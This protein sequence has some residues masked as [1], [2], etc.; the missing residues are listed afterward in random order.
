MRDN[1][2]FASDG[3]KTASNLTSLPKQKL[4]MAKKGKAWRESCVDAIVNHGNSSSWAYNK[5]RRA[6]M[7]SGYDMYNGIYGEGDFTKITNPYRVPD[8]SPATARNFN[9]VRPYVDALLGRE[10]NRP[11]EYTSIRTSNLSPSMEMEEMKQSLIDYFIADMLSGLS[12]GEQQ[13]FTERLQTGELQTPEA[14]VDAQRSDV[15]DSAEITN[16]YMLKKLQR[17]LCLDHE[18]IKLFKDALLSSEEHLCIEPRHGRPTVR[19][20]NPENITYEWYPGMEFIDQASWVCEHFRMPHNAVYDMLA[21]YMTSADL[22]KLLKTG[23][24]QGGMFTPSLSTLIRTDLITPTGD[25]MLS[26]ALGDMVDVWHAVWRGF[27]K[28]GFLTVMDPETGETVENL[29]VD[30]TYKAMGENEF[31][32]W[33]WVTEIWHGYRIGSDL[34]VGIEP[35]PYQHIT[36]DNYNDNRLPYTGAVHSNTNSVPRSFVSLLK[37]LQ[38]LYIIVW[39]R[40]ELAI[41]RDHGR[42]AIVDVTQ[43]PSSQEIPLPVW[44]HYLDTMGVYL[45]NP[46][47][48][49]PDNPANINRAPYFNQ[50]GSMDLSMSNTIIQYTQLLLEIE[51]L[52]SRLSGVSPEMMGEAQHNREAVGVYNQNVNHAAAVVSPWFWLHDQVKRRALQYLLN[53][54]KWL[55]RQSDQKYLDYVLDDGSRIILELSNEFWEDMDVYVTNTDRDMVAVQQIQ[56]LLQPA[57]QNGAT[58]MDAAEILTQDNVGVLKKKLRE[59]EDRRQAQMQQQMQAEQQAAQMQLEADAAQKEADRAMIKYKVDADNQTK[60]AVAEISAYRF[61]QDLD[62][63]NDGISDVLQIAEHQLNEY[64]KIT[65]HSLDLEKVRAERDKAAKEASLKEKE[66]K[67]KRELEQSKIELE[68]KKLRA[69]ERIQKQKDDAALERERLKAR[70]AIRNKVSGEK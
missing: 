56:Q 20:V 45:V 70:T 23:A 48:R 1:S 13:A 22:D 36:I 68:E 63:D 55:W 66:I 64:D 3:T 58:L 39:Y 9:I 54:T 17:E 4:P 27:R 5:L 18:F 10:I 59:I 6:D 7:Q 61:Q 52:C 62:V 41:A 50:Y 19:R 49:D 38:E 43:I 51:R 24:D 33:K 8:G 21:D 60:I 44:L 30:E 69:Q 53:L 28:V 16:Y 57:M 46:S 65:Q 15:R 25:L 12:P 37:P 29:I 11:F 35:Y 26:S 31:V 34:Y 2:I 14:L 32:E 40:L 47:E 67:T 42:A